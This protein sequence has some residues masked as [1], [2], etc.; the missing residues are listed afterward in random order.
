MIVAT[1]GGV[2]IGLYLLARHLIEWFPGLKNLQ[3]KPL[4]YLGDLLPFVLAW[5]YG[6]LAVLT[7]VGLIGWAFDTALWASNW[8]GDAALWLG[9]GESPGQAAGAKYRPLGVF[10]NCVMLLFTLLVPT[11][12]NHT[13]AGPAVKRGVWCGLCLGTSST[14]GGLVAIPL[15]QGV[16]WVGAAT[17]GAIT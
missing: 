15:A 9:V 8:L 13:K 1:L 10:G 3:K 7:S 5:C 4:V 6:A 11:I 17:Y 2:T 14:I 12:V 16:D